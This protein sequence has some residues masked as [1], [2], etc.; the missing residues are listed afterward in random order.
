VSDALVGQAEKLPLWRAICGFAV[1]GSLILVAI[2]VAPVYIANYRLTQYVQTLAAQS[3]AARTPDE[4]F[5]TEIVE[6]AH[7]LHLPVQPTDVTVK[8]AGGRVQL[9]LSRYKAQLYHADLHLSGV[10]TR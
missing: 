3:D 2:V 5:R 8:H 10:S 1:L 4:T 9:Q 7:Q 6:R